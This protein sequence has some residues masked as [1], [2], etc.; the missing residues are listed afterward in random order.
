LKPD[1]NG[2]FAVAL[3]FRNRKEF[4]KKLVRLLPISEL[5]KELFQSNEVLV[6]RFSPLNELLRRCYGFG[7]IF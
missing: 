1:L 6:I 3:G 4:I 7:Q 2:G 5:A